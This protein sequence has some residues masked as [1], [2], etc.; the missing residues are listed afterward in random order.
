MTMCAFMSGSSS[1]RQ[2][3]GVEVRPAL[4]KAAHRCRSS[5]SWGNLA[6]LAVPHEDGPLTMRRAKVRCHHPATFHE[7]EDVR[8]ADVAK[9]AGSDHF[10]TSLSK[11]DWPDC[12]SRANFP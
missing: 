8:M 1:N 9:E 2:D 3:R 10:F 5:R 12:S 4:G 11:S 7:V 6:A